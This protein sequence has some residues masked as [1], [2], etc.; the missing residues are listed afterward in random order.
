MVNK[1]ALKQSI[2][3]VLDEH[4]IEDGSLREDLVDRLV[5]DFADEIYDDD[6]EEAVEEVA[7]LEG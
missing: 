6:D 4:E 1:N 3:E 7:E 2:K 5:Q